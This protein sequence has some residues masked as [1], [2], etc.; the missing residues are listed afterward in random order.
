MLFTELKAS[1]QVIG[2]TSLFHLPWNL[3][4]LWGPYLDAY[5]TKR[6]WIAGA[7]LVLVVCLLGLAVVAPMGSA[8]LG[9]AAALFGVMA[10]VAATHDIAIDGYYLE[11]L[12]EAEQAAFVGLRAPAFRVS[13]LVVSGPT[14][15]LVKSVGWLAA[16]VGCAALMGALFAYHVFLPPAETARRPMGHILQAVLRPAALGVLVGIGALAFAAYTLS[17]AWSGFVAGLS[18]SAPALGAI[19]GRIDL[20]GGIAL[21]LLAGLLA[22]LAALPALKQR[23]ARSDSFYARAFMTFLAQPQ[24]GRI[25]AF[26]VLFRVGESFLMK[27]KYPFLKSVGL[28]LGE[29]GLLNGVVGMIAAL[30]APAVGGY[31]ISRHGLRRWIWPFVAAQNLLNLLYMAVAL[32][33]VPGEPTSLVTLGAVITVEMFGA[34]LGTAVFMVYLMRCALPEHRAA[35]MAILTALMSVGFTVAGVASGFL[36]DAM[37]YGAYFALTFVATIPGMALIF[38]IPHLDERPATAAR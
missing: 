1:L 20:A 37:G 10:L 5:G 29:Y 35:H 31:L 16:F 7:E 6:R 13:M 24:V 21:A 28:G 15:I 11:A 12:D 2:L 25:L 9:V 36:A 23:M 38:F 18:S 33:A 26:V 27:M 34:G 32:S 8:G 22:T 30:I 3:K 4:F 19:L 17:E 14:L